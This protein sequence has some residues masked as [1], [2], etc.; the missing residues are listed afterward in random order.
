MTINRHYKLHTNSGI[1]VC[2]WQGHCW[3]QLLQQLQPLSFTTSAYAPRKWPRISF[4]DATVSFHCINDFTLAGLSCLA[5]GNSQCWLSISA[6]TAHLLPIYL[7][8]IWHP[9]WITMWTSGMFTP[10]PRATVATTTRMWLSCRVNTRC[11]RTLEFSSDCLWYI[12]IIRF[13]N[14]FD[15]STNG[16][17]ESSDFR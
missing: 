3:T 12:S 1:P 10:N 9:Q 14:I 7:Y 17:T 13:F 11:T 16:S 8:R 15:L 4:S 2:A 5:V 6:C